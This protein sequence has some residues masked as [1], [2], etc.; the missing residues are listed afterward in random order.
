MLV[1]AN[2]VNNSD[3]DKSS[4]GKLKKILVANRGEIAIRV[5]RA[6]T[7]LGLR[8]VAI[9]SEQDRFA[10]HRFKADESYLI[11]GGKGPVQA[12]MSIQEIL[13]IAD[14]ANA[15]C[16]HPGYG[17]LS[18]NPEFCEVVEKSGIRF[19][20]P[21]ATVMRRLGNKIQARELAA[22]VNVSVMPASGPLPQSEREI[23]RIAEEIGYPLMLK[24]SWGGGGRGMRLINNQ[25]ELMVQ[26]RAGKREARA[27][28][29]SEEV[30]LEKFLPKARHVEVQILGDLHGNLIHL[31]ERD[32]SMQRRN[33]KVVE[34]APAAY[35]SQESRTSLCSAA[36]RL[37]AEVNYSCAGTV[38][39]L[40]DFDSGEF[41]FIEV[42]PRIQV[43]HTVTEEV[44]G[45][46]LVKAQ[47]R[48]VEGHKIGDK[49]GALPAQESVRLNG[50][51]L[52]CRVTTE[53]PEERFIPD[54]GRIT[55][56]RGA[57]G[58]GIRLDGGTAY[59]GA[60]ITPYYDSL[61]EKVTAWAPTASEAAKRMDRALRE[62]RIRGVKTNLIFLEALVSNNK[63]QRWEYTT[64]FID[65]TPE[66]LEFP[67]RRDRA[68]RLLS[69][70]A[71]VMVNGNPEVV[72]R[73]LPEKSFDLPHMPKVP[74]GDLPKG[75]RD[76]LK[77]FGPKRFSNWILEQQRLLITDTTLRDAH[78]SLLATRL[79]TY[80]MLKIAP[81]YAR[82]LPE[83]FSLECWGGA[84]FD[85]AMRFLK[86]DPWDRLVKLRQAFPNI[87]T[88]M[89]LRS[90]NAVGYKNYPDNV[91]QYFIAQSA[92]AGIDVFRI[93]DCLNWVDNMRVAID[94]VCNE[95]KLCE[96]A[97]CYTGDLTNPDESQ[98]TLNYY[99][100]KAKQLE[101]SGVH[102]LGIKD[103][104]GLCKPLAAKQLV[105]ALKQEIGII[106]LELAHFC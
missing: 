84:T 6:A 80:D 32:C 69:F 7:E 13:K 42:N 53:D 100:K 2:R 29:G 98:Y 39:F 95:D 4:K 16:I 65:E 48:V 11:G 43:E 8:T 21:E 30:Y 93:F 104:A 9:Y 35:L 77:E 64:R 40:M 19:I 105:T 68:T 79:R 78:Q 52:Q 102:I 88:Q 67:K 99:I 82:A 46:D 31:F 71:D 85:V 103:M 90:A 91:V 3:M 54:H 63:F 14:A 101:K 59:S 24:A 94:A 61:L 5:F 1:A 17:F 97:I 37:L 20:G 36:L 45:I 92:Q 66:L 70:L 74:D 18:E 83:L 15:D 60:I 49:D 34:R 86:E 44:T 50:H 10:L 87:L 76:I 72:G 89:L 55:A 75:T 22:K 47:I 33:Q 96:G 26:V 106:S 23:Q 81:F 62:F 27:S 58:F 57:T 25:K 12:Y 56:Y 28:F 38:E 73:E 41:F 51:A